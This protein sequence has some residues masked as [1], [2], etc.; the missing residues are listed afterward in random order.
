MKSLLTPLAVASVALGLTA[1]GGD[2]TSSGPPAVTIKAGQPVHVKG[3][4]Y[5]FEPANIVLDGGGGTKFEFQND[6]ALA[7][8]L[9]IE[10]DGADIGGTPTFQGGDTKTATVP[11]QT[12]NYELICTVGDHASRGMTGK[13]TVK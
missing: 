7:H 2:E 10:Q 9:R 3:T 13:L 5:K 12:G 11:L 4:D 6:G 8:N 1:C